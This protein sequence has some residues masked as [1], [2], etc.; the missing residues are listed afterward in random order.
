MAQTRR[1]GMCKTVER[2]YPKRRGFR[3]TVI[4]SSQLPGGDF[5]QRW[6]GGSGSSDG[7]QKLVLNKCFT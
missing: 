3:P 5:G 2:S 7:A 4:G 1:M 6:A